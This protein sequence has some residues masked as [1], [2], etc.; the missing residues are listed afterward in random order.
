MAL[1]VEGKYRLIN[2]LGE[3]SFGQIF[4]GQNKNTGEHVA[5]KIEKTSGK[6]LLKNEAKMYSLFADIKGVPTM[7]SYGVEGKYHYLVMDMLGNSLEYVKNLC[8]GKLSLKTVLSLTLQML[9]RL[10][11]I[12]ELGIIHRDIKPD[13]FLLGKGEDSHTL[14]IID[15][16]LAKPYILGGTHVKQEGG[17]KLTGTARYASLHVHHG[18]LPS[19]RDD[20][21]SLGYMALYLLHGTLPWQ[22]IIEEK[23]E[24]KHARICQKKEDICLWEAFPEVPGE[25]ITYMNYCENLEYDAEPDYN[26]LKTLFLNLY[27]LHRYP[28]DNIYDWTPM[29]DDDNSI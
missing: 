14:Y 26:Y 12:H 7:R 1:V 15:F 27:R 20:L 5:V 3:G 23:R 21:I 19:R 2:K 28:I 18:M 9:R 29:S 4:A 24:D 13:N 10:E 25:F 8:G 16:G 22:G 11:A 6:H 17:R